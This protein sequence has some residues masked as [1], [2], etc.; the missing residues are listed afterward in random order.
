MN[1][2]SLFTSLACVSLFSRH[3]LLYLGQV[4]LTSFTNIVLVLAFSIFGKNQQIT[5]LP[6]GQSLIFF[7]GAGFP[8]VAK[9]VPWIK[10]P[11][12]VFFACKHFGTGVLI[13]T[14]FVHVSKSEQTKLAPSNSLIFH[15]HILTF[16]ASCCPLP[17]ATC[18]TPVFL[19]CSPSSTPRCQVLS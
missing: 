13:A 12:K 19:I 4:E 15:T 5:S 17:S 9:K 3:H 10:I 6:L 2:I 7:L 18:L 1:T 14:A 8:V 16:S 11:P